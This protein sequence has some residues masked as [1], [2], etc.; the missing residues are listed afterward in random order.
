[1]LP[2]FGV[3]ERRGLNSSASD[4]PVAGRP[5]LLRSAVARFLDNARIARGLSRNTLRGYSSELRELVA[6]LERHDVRTIRSVR[7]DDLLVHLTGLARR[8]KKSTVARRVSAIRELFA[9][10]IAAGWRRGSNPAAGINLPRSKSGGT[11]FLTGEE[12]DRILRAPELSTPRGVRNAA[13]LDLLY[14]AGLRAA[15]IVRL[16]LTAVDRAREVLHVA[17]RRGAWV[18]PLVGFASSALCEYL[19]CGRRDL[20]RARTG[21]PGRQKRIDALFVTADLQG[22]AIHPDTVHRILRRAAFSAGITGT[23]SPAVLR[24]SLA[25]HLFDNEVDTAVIVAVLR[26]DLPAARLLYRGARG[27]WPAVKRRKRWVVPK[28]SE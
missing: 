26:I 27:Q 9:F 25:V 13:I 6:G 24:R 22:V 18:I 10:A 21:R 16:K 23:P 20:L 19:S 7:R 1:V 11:R 8:L 2:C 28:M 14:G 3:A 5:I 15:E 17:T 4:G 12:V